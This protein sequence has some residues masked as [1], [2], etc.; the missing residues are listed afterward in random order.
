MPKP[1]PGVPYTVVSGDNLSKIASRAYGDPKKWRLIWKANQNTLRSSDPDRIYP[2]EVLQIPPDPDLAKIASELSLGGPDDFLSDKDPDDFTLKLGKKEVPVL[3]GRVMRTIDTVTDSFTASIAWDS[4]DDEVT[5]LILPDS[6]TDA[7]VYLGGYLVLTGRLYKSTPELTENGYVVG[8]EGF[9]LTADVA[10]SVVKPPLE[11]KK[12]TLKQRAESLL[13][14]FGLT[15]IYEAD[16]GDVFDRV[17]AT[18]SEKVFDH[19]A[20]LAR[21]RS[22]LISST[23]KGELIFYQADVSKP[24]GVIE[25]GKPPFLQARPDFD[26]RKRFF[27]YRVVGPTPK[28]STGRN[29]LEAVAKDENVPKSRF[30]MTKAMDATP[31]N[32]QQI[33]DWERSKAIV[34]AYTIDCDVSSWYA[35]NDELWQVNKIVTVKAKTLFAPKGFDFLIKSVEYIFEAGG[36]TAVLGL[37]PPN[38]YTGKPLEVPWGKKS[39]I[40]GLL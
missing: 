18:A 32:I 16:T 6:F 4:D 30:T 23:P 27:S 13:E 33:A 12:V 21:Q 3:A 7:K 40:S 31:G 35:P 9:S 2:G 22:V 37:V 38:A 39:L 14:P 24:V 34:D 8:L 25:E 28:K 5:D 15:V 19:L 10:D 36:T 29:A 20:E 26:G 1:M 11:V 17:T